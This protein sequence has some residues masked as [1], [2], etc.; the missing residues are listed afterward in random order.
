MCKFYKNKNHQQLLK[1]YSQTGIH[2]R[3]YILWL[4]PLWISPSFNIITQFLL[5]FLFLLLIIPP[6]LPPL[7]PPHP[8]CPSR[9]GLL[10]L[11]F[12]EIEQDHRDY[13][14]HAVQG[15]VNFVKCRQFARI[16]QQVQKYQSTPY[17]LRPVDV[18][19]TLAQALSLQQSS[20]SLVL[21][22]VCVYIVIAAKCKLT[23]G[24]SLKLESSPYVI[25]I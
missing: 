10:L 9:T 19:C 12:E 17:N 3:M 6:S 11:G 5:C 4:R 15:V 16:I 14:P 21:H 7:S 18:S 1:Q 24:I 23:T 13:L 2:V 25:A 8:H 22:H 20:I